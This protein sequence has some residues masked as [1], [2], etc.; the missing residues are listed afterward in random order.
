MYVYIYNTYIYIY[1]Y[2]WIYTYINVYSHTK[3]HALYS[4]TGKTPAARSVHHC[5]VD[6]YSRTGYG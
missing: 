1:V 3:T 5:D 2:I 6:I 4:L